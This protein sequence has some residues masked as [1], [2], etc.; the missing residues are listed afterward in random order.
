MFDIQRTIVV[1]HVHPLPFNN[2]Q[3][4]TID[5]IPKIMFIGSFVK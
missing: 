4:A 3:N 2:H 5:T 1:F